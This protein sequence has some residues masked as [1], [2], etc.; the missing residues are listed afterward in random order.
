M[1]DIASPPPNGLFW[2]NGTVW[3]AVTSGNPLPV[4]ASVTV[5][6]TSL[7]NVNITQ[8]GSVA[9]AQGATTAAHSFPFAI[10]TD[11]TIAVTGS[12]AAPALQNVNI[13][14]IGSAAAATGHGTAAGA[15]RVELPTDGTG[16]VG[17]GAGTQNIGSVVASGT[18][19]VNGTVPVSGSVSAIQSGSWT[20]T[21]VPSGTQTVGGQAASGVAVAGNPLLLGARAATAD[22]AAVADGQAVRILADKIGRFINAG[23]ALPENNLDGFVTS[24]TTA[25]VTLIASPGTALAIN[26]TDLEL[27]NT[28]TTQ[29]VITL[30]NTVATQLVIP[31]NG[32]REIHFQTPI[33]LA[34]GNP[35]TFTMT[36]AVTSVLAGAQGFK[37]A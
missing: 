16:V 31:A 27:S 17:L 26:V 20:T 30:N 21:I 36:P 34:A 10:A 4:N 11:Q 35:L 9:I 23:F 33:K 28:S 29:T 24:G 18:L 37:S 5:S 8:V 3:S 7:Q 2:L 1:T 13:T 6:P 19:S 12:F 14:Q 25:A 15:L 22:P 32:G